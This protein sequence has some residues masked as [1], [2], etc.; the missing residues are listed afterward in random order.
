MLKRIVQLTSAKTFDNGHKR[1]NSGGITS[2]RQTAMSSFLPSIENA[3]YKITAKIVSLWNNERDPETL[4]GDLDEKSELLMRKLWQLLL[5]EEGE[6]VDSAA[7]EDEEAL[8]PAFVAEAALVAWV[9]RKYASRKATPDVEAVRQRMAI[10]MQIVFRANGIPISFTARLNA[11]VEKIYEGERDKDALRRAMA[12]KEKKFKS[13][14]LGAFV[15]K[16]LSLMETCDEAD[17]E[18]KSKKDKAMKRLVWTRPKFEGFWA[19]NSAAFRRIVQLCDKE[20]ALKYANERILPREDALIGKADS[21]SMSD[22]P[23]VL[24][25]RYL[26]GH[27]CD[28]CEKDI[29]RDGYR[30]SSGCDFDVCMKC[31]A[32][33]GDYKV[34]TSAPAPTGYDQGDMEKERGV[35]LREFVASWTKGNWLV[36]GA[37]KKMWEGVRDYDQLCSGIEE[38]DVGSRYLVLRML[39]LTEEFGISQPKDAF[40]SGDGGAVQGGGKAG[41]AGSSSGGGVARVPPP[42]KEPHEPRCGME[43]LFGSA[44]LMLLGQNGSTIKV[45]DLVAFDT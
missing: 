43:K 17:L 12:G 5:I 41:S 31:A 20:C 3:G 18:A 45:N 42:A 7:D 24:T 1:F 2:E 19:K 15:S 33:S 6:D 13:L 28:V 30:C 14:E 8:H 38:H 25:Y 35:V 36:E 29:E 4:F 22:H 39:S 40:A 27:T 21:I 23:H 16:V 37:I 10:Y 9:A 34:P 26:V 11:G 44:D 32:V